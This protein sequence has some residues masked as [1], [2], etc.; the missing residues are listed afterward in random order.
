MSIFQNFNQDQEDEIITEA[1]IVSANTGKKVFILDVL[2]I[3]REDYP[4]LT[5]DNWMAAAETVSEKLLNIMM[6]Y[7][8]HNIE[9]KFVT[10]NCNKFFAEILAKILTFIAKK[11]KK[12]LK[13]VK[14]QSLSMQLNVAYGPDN[15]DDLLALWL[16]NNHPDADILS[17][18]R[19]NKK[20]DHKKTLLKHSV[21]KINEL[22]GENELM[23]I[24]NCKNKKYPIIENSIDFSKI[25]NGKKTIKYSEFMVDD[26]HN[27]YD[28]DGDGDIVMKDFYVNFKIPAKNKPK[29]LHK[30]HKM[31]C[32]KKNLIKV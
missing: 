17:R 7:T 14:E 31:T 26:N 28:Y 25:N 16:Q 19:M 18:D 30:T 13:N 9:I 6:L 5:S 32:I 2:N 29:I 10:K 23:D 12:K 11:I 24:L 27:Y 3:C 1:S 20:E 22:I 21:I 4:T 15:V 8:S